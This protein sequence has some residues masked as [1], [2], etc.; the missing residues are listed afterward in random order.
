MRDPKRLKTMGSNYA[1]S[2]EIQGITSQ[3]REASASQYRT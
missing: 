1:A 3:S 2:F